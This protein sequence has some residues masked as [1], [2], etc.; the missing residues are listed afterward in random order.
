MDDDELRQAL[1]RFYATLWQV[2]TRAGAV[3]M[4]TANAPSMPTSACSRT[5]LNTMPRRWSPKRKA[6]KRALLADELAAELQEI[7]IVRYS[8]GRILAKQ[9]G[10]RPYEDPVKGKSLTARMWLVDQ[11]R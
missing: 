8:I 5:S 11:I 9:S 2:E 7:Q 1:A 6:A 10:I 4:T 3:S